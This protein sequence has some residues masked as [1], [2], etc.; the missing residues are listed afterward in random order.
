MRRKIE[1][2]KMTFSISLDVD[3]LKIINETI[4]NRSK[5]I[6]N[7]IIEEMCKSLEIKEELTNKKIIL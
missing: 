4:A 1:K 6:Q 5:Y 3:V 2:K 7:C